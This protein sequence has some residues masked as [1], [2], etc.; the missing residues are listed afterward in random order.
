MCVFWI[1]CGTHHG[2]FLGFAPT[3]QRLKVSVVFLF[4]LGDDGIAH[5]RRILD[6]TG[7]VQQTVTRDAADQ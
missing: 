5:E 3:G 7:V 1:V 6:F 4:E 2:V